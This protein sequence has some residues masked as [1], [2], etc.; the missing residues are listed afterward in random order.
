MGKK[1][2]C[3]IHN[4]LSEAGHGFQTMTWTRFSKM[5]SAASLPV[6]AKRYE[7]NLD[8]VCRILQKCIKNGWCYRVSSD[9]FALMTHPE[10]NINWEEL[11]NKDALEGLFVRC[12]ENAFLYEIRLSCHP[13]QFNVLASENP[14]SVDNTIRE[15]NHH[16][17]FMSKL[18][19]FLPPSPET[20]INIHLNCSKG[21]PRDIAK[22]FKDNLDRLNPST[23]AR[24]V[25]ETEDKGIWH[26]RNLVDY[27]HELTGVPITF[28]YLHHKCNPGGLTEE[29]A[30]KL[31]AQTWGKHKPL[32]HFC[33]ALPG[34]NNPRKHAN[35][36]TYTP[37]TYGYDVDLDYEFKDKE[38]ALEVA[39]KLVQNLASEALSV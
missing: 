35:L 8:V 33:E 20:P 30:F 4:G 2:L 39:E 29:E 3:C 38:T 13:D 5:G 1:G 14:V 12:A 23:K 16:D 10:A 31:C 17:W 26:T 11:P 21:D 6:L 18:S 36:P 32:F 15:L 24:L 37:N 25:V 7:N 27:I 34:Q 9:I 22:R 19:P 28:D